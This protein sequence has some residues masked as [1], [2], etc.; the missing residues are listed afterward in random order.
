MARRA[1]FKGSAS[2]LRH[3][4][5]DAA[6]DR[7]V[8][9]VRAWRFKQPVAERLSSRP[10]VDHHPVDYNLLVSKTRP[11]QK[12][13][14]ESALPSRPY[15]LKDTRIGERRGVTFALQLEF[16]AVDAARDIGR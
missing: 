10:A 4:C 15:G 6:A 11:L 14:T 2:K 9:G 16:L 13:Q 3:S 7:R 8:I 5:V 1:G 12:Q